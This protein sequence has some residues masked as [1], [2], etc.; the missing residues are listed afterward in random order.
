MEA[1]TVEHVERDRLEPAV[2]EPKDEA[3]V[4]PALLPFSQRIALFSSAADA[5]SPAPSRGSQWNTPARTVTSTPGSTTTPGDT[6]RASTAYASYSAA[7]R[8]SL[9]LFDAATAAAARDAAYRFFT[10]RSDWQGRPTAATPTSKPAGGPACAEAATQTDLDPHEESSTSDECPELRPKPAAPTTATPGCASPDCTA[11]L[12]IRAS[13]LRGA[14][15]CG[16]ATA[17]A[18][19]AAALQQAAVQQQLLSAAAALQASAADAVAADRP[20][21]AVVRLL[22]DYIAEQ[23]QQQ[24][25]TKEEASG[26]SAGSVSEDADGC[27]AAQ[28]APS[29]P[30]A[31]LLAALLT[32][33]AG[34]EREA[35][36][37]A[38]PEGLAEEAVRASTPSSPAA[39]VTAGHSE[40]G[41]SESGSEVG[42]EA[43]SGVAVAALQQQVAALREQMRQRALAQYDNNRMA[44]VALDRSLARLNH[45]ASAIALG[46]GAGAAVSGPPRSPSYSPPRPAA[47]RGL[48]HAA[49]S[50]AATCAS[51][52]GSCSKPAAAA[53]APAAEAEAEAPAPNQARSWFSPG[54]WLWGSPPP[55]GSHAPGS[56]ARQ[57]AG[58][59]PREAQE[60]VEEQEQ[61]LAA[62]CRERDGLAQQCAALQRQCSGLIAYVAMLGGSGSG[63]GGGGAATAAPAL[64]SSV[65]GSSSSSSSSSSLPLG[66]RAAGAPGAEVGR[67][68]QRPLERAVG[69]AEAE[70]STPAG[71]VSDARLWVR[72]TASPPRGPAA[73]PAHSE[74]LLQEGAAGQQPPCVR[75]KFEMVDWRQ[76]QQQQ[77]R[78]A[79]VRVRL[80]VA[81]GP[82]GFGSAV[83][84][85]EEGVASAEAAAGAGAGCHTPPAAPGS[86]LAAPHLVI[87]ASPH[88][89][90]AADPGAAA[91]WLGCVPAAGAGAGAVA[92][93]LLQA[94][95]GHELGVWLEEQGQDQEPWG[96][97]LQ[98][99]ISLPSQLLL[100][101]QREREQRRRALGA[102]FPAGGAD[103][104]GAGV[105]T[106]PGGLGY[107]SSLVAAVQQLVRSL[108][109]EA[110]AASCAAPGAAAA[111]ALP[112]TESVIASPFATPSVP[113]AVGGG[114][115]SGSGG[116]SGNGTASGGAEPG[117]SPQGPRPAPA[118]VSAALDSLRRALRQLLGDSCDGG[119]SGAG[120]GAGVSLMP[121]ALCYEEGPPPPTPCGLA[122][123]AGMNPVAAAGGLVAAATEEQEQLLPP[124]QRSW[125]APAPGDK[126]RAGA[127]AGADADDVGPHGDDERGGCCMGE[128]LSAA[129]TAAAASDAAAVA[130]AAAVL[131]RAQAAAAEFHRVYTIAAAANGAG[132]LASCGGGAAAA[133]DGP[134]LPRGRSSPPCSPRSPGPLDPVDSASHTG[135]GSGDGGGE[136]DDEPAGPA[137][138]CAR[139]TSGA[140]AG[141]AAPAAGGGST[142]QHMIL[143]GDGDGEWHL[144]TADTGCC[145]DSSGCAFSDHD[146]D[147]HGGH[148]EELDEADWD[149][150]AAAAQASGGS[151]PL[152]AAVGFL[153]EQLQLAHLEIVALTT[154]LG[155]LSH[156]RAA[157]EVRTRTHDA[158]LT[159]LAL[160]EGEALM[161]LAG[162]RQQLSAE[163]AA[164][165]RLG[166]QCEELQN[167]LLSGI[168]DRS[169]SS[170]FTSPTKPQQSVRVEPA[171]AGALQQQ[172]QQ[173]QRQQPQSLPV[174]MTGQRLSLARLAPAGP[175]PQPQA[176]QPGTQ[177]QPRQQQQ[178]QHHQH[179]KQ[180][181]QQQP[182][183]H[184]VS[185]YNSV[186]PR[187]TVAAVGGSGSAAVF[188]FKLPVALFGRS[189][190]K[191]VVLDS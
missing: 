139:R 113:G 26:K 130:V 131:S 156:Q 118:A 17:A 110:T 133:A 9:R 93:P 154:Q 57:R 183:K 135:S 132:D 89:R 68:Q 170:H 147:G 121:P 152:L 49:G 182:Q 149:A 137:R 12:V 134:A 62:L 123:G 47:P 92:A 88:K 111:G 75:L 16:A 95:G 83:M 96:H 22:A 103:T 175:L 11:Q 48:T 109:D 151:E 86:P 60:A 155:S 42:E 81:P 177:Q 64:D 105:G 78:A 61:R 1:N 180:Q 162:L 107:N 74:L 30:D 178:Y 115:G 125:S 24:A 148:E 160:A 71:L 104:A 169:P 58:R 4:D 191:P 15:E 76:Q 172:Q 29:A 168:P 157:A 65:T 106:S 7:P 190:T 99:S 181:Q 66:P 129:C 46:G 141:T 91:E 55:A 166:A 94:A 18:G 32:A 69:P 25:A 173:Q 138:W 79:H 122:T 126:L 158:A 39:D 119:D 34:A 56:H 124:A 116:R 33:Q 8:S 114:S 5:S 171:S 108:E 146:H 53:P 102:R 20:W 117:G 189:P 165:A 187:R 179:Q 90:A 70:V 54:R 161:E 87:G 35:A 85:G 82:L 36:A 31:R 101:R 59:G 77:G 2:A 142:G 176:S 51:V 184:H 44:A 150:L 98:Q 72:V 13:A 43:D 127:G 140:G 97:A 10:L 3:T 37:G 145:V 21:L 136:N 40:Q 128:T 185:R 73:P 167:M 19:A 144:D 14:D 67:Q 164:R 100:Q 84:E 50:P 186:P 63:G 27:A 159:Q 143:Y 38:E 188:R 28:A 153:R 120:A 163:R 45:M 174:D 41:G 80:V 6:R 52:S 112:A 23:Q